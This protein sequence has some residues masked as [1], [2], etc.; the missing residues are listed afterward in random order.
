MGNQGKKGN[1]RLVLMLCIAALGAGLM[2]AVALAGTSH[3]ASN[4]VTTGQHGQDCAPGY[5]DTVG[6]ACEHNGNGGGNCGDNQSGNNNGQGNGG[7]DNGFGHRG[8][9][10]A[11]TSTSTSTSTSTTTSTST[12]TSTTTTTTTPHDPTT[13]VTSTTTTTAPLS[14]P[15]DPCARALAA[16]GTHMVVGRRSLLVVTALGDGGNA[17]AGVSV[18]IRGAGL[19]AEAATDAGGVARFHLRPRSAGVVRISLRQTAA[20][21]DVSE[22]GQVLG[23]F[24]PPR[25]NFTG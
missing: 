21:G 22:L 17:M 20:C 15:A 5:H 14:P 25:P 18:L 19:S 7:N 23:A 8:D 11:T 2:S 4:G 13:S 16:R 24:A 10:D 12:P 1:A 3:P 6:G 9:C